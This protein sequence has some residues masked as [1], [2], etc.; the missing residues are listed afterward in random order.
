MNCSREMVLDRVDNNDNFLFNRFVKAVIERD[1]TY[2]P[3]YDL[4]DFIKPSNTNCTYDSS[5]IKYLDAFDDFYGAIQFTTFQQSSSLPPSPR[6]VQ[7][8]LVIDRIDDY[9][10]ERTCKFFIELTTGGATSPNTLC[11]KAPIFSTNR[12]SDTL[13]FFENYLNQIMNPGDS[14]SEREIMVSEYVKTAARI[15]MPTYKQSANGVTLVNPVRAHPVS[16]KINIISVE[17]E[18]WNWN[19]TNIFNPLYNNVRDAFEDHMDILEAIELLICIGNR[20]LLLEDYAKVDTESNTDTITNFTYTVTRQEA[21]DRIDEL[22][23]IVTLVEFGET[24]FEAVDRLCSELTALNNNFHP[25][26]FRILA[27]VWET[28]ANKKSCDGP[29]ASPVKIRSDKG[30]GQ[31]MQ[32]TWGSYE[33]NNTEIV[34]QAEYQTAVND[35]TRL[36]CTGFGLSHSNPWINEFLGMSWN[37]LGEIVPY[38]FIREDDPYS[39]HDNLNAPYIAYIPTGN[40]LKVPSDGDYHYEVFIYSVSGQLIY[41]G[42]TKA[43]LYLEPIINSGGI[44]IIRIVGSNETKSLKYVNH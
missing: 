15:I 40:M 36:S 25:T 16:N 35:S 37:S 5:E 42:S 24:P 19:D 33:I 30:F 11:K 3:D 31:Y 39:D 23:D 44:Y 4:Q 27:N 7:I 9:P 38:G 10:I 1:I 32:N 43:E 17:H 14:A 2:L 28:G 20:P 18:Y 13:L 34:I 41:Q 21:A 12:V 22:V 29:N 8:G 26:K 6:P